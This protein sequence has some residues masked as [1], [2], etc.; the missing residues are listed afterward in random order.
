MDAFVVTGALLLEPHRSLSLSLLLHDM[1]RNSTSKWCE[2]RGVNLAVIGS[3]GGALPSVLHAN[4]PQLT[5]D[6]VDVS[7]LVCSVACEH[8]HLHPDDRLRLHVVR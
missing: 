4:F 2:E 6:A 1:M 8:F 7:D 3:G 5:V